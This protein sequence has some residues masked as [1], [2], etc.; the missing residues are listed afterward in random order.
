MKPIFSV[1]LMILFSVAAN[2]QQKQLKLSEYLKAGYAVVGYHWDAAR[3]QH[4]VLLQIRGPDKVHA[5]V[6]YLRG[7]R[8]VPAKTDGCSVV[9]D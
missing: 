4:S 2:A 6:C 7:G 1:C 5:V 3:D 9:D 8:S